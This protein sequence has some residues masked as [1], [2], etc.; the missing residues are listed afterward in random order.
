MWYQKAS[1]TIIEVIVNQYA[2]KQHY[3]VVRQLFA[4]FCC[5]VAHGRVCAN[6][7]KKWHVIPK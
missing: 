1:P 6:P 7:N 5:I 2:S 3:A 4:N